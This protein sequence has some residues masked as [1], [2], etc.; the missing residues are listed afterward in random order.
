[1]DLQPP[2][3]SSLSKEIAAGYA[4]AIL[5]FCLGTFFATKLHGG[6]STAVFR[7]FFVV[8]AL[9]V[10]RFTFAWGRLRGFAA[11]NPDGHVCFSNVQRNIVMTGLMLFVLL[12]VASPALMISFQL[13][14]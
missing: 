7:F 12:F 10:A 14:R 9:I 13:A 3:F 6:E 8:G 4:L 1:M 2:K 5:T 11:M